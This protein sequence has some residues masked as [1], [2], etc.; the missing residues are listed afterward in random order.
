MDFCD[1]TDKLTIHTAQTT[2]PNGT[3]MPVPKYSFNLAAPEDVGG[4]PEYAGWQQQVI[5]FSGIEDGC[6]V[7]LDYEVAT[8]PG[9]IPWL[10]GDL[11]ISDE[12]PI[13]ERVVSVSVPD[14]IE[15]KSAVDGMTAQPEK[16]QAGGL[17]T[18]RWTFKNVPATPG[19]AQS[20]RWE[21]RCP[22]L[23]FTS[24]KGA[25]EWIGT[26]AKKIEAG[27]QP[28]EKVKKFAEGDG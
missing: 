1:G 23:R 21:K 15:L 20:M 18:F 5:C 28:D 16:T 14:G 17:T 7:E 12:Y 19:E 11:R 2:L 22:R 10:Q 3:V 13:V 9:V 27:A 6:V 8:K 25:E 24:C 4:W 26:L